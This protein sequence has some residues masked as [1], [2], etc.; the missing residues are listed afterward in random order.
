M[1]ETT[2]TYRQE[3]RLKLVVVNRHD[4]LDWFTF[5]VKGWP[6]TVAVPILT[7][8]PADVQVIDVRDNYH[9]RQIEFMVSHPSFDPVPEGQVPPRLPDPLQQGKMVVQFMEPACRLT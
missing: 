8:L 7:G 3:R 2:G 4:V 9:T 6:E 1:S 5:A